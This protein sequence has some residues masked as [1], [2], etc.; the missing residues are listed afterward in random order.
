MF[1]GH[2]LLAFAL[3]ATLAR[4]YGW[5]PARALSFGLLAGAFGLAP[6]VDILYAPVGVLGTSGPLDAAAGFW[7]AGNEVHRAVTH[8]LLVAGATSLAAGL[9][10]T[11]RRD[12]RFAAGTALVGIVTVVFAASGGLAAAV[13]T[14]FG[15]TCFGLAHVGRDGLGFTP[16]AVVAAGLVGTLSHPFGDLFTGEPPALL[17]PVDTTLLA[18]RITLHPDPTLHLLGTLFA[19]L[20]TAWLAVLVVLW[21][22]DGESLELG[23]RLSVGTSRRFD[24]S[25]GLGLGY[26]GAA[27]V[28]PAPT[29]SVSYHFVFPLLAVGVAVASVSVVRR[30]RDGPDWTE[31]VEAA[32]CSGLAAITL[33]AGAYA[34]AYLALA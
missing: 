28:L 13:V 29:L 5:S 9:W 32:L 25:A 34:V 23:G 4:L 3:A 11:G 12:G 30:L 31:R 18:S 6:D 16:A 14:V 24:R 22:R 8:S 1:V 10:T 33:A 19:E 15:V 27:A 7:A 2:G 20:A 26:A 21:L 17:S